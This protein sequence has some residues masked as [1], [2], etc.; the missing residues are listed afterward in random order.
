MRVGWSESP[1]QFQMGLAAKMGS[2][3]GPSTDVHSRGCDQQGSVGVPRAQT[4]PGGRMGRVDLDE[5]RLMSRMSL[6]SL[7]TS[8]PSFSYLLTKSTSSQHSESGGTASQIR[9]A[10]TT[11]LT[12]SSHLTS[13]CTHH[14]FQA[15]VIIRPGSPAQGQ[16]GVIA[17]KSWALTVGSRVPTADSN[18]KS[19]GNSDDPGEKP[20]H[21]L[22][23]AVK[24]AAVPSTKRGPQH[25]GTPKQSQSPG[26]LH[27]GMCPSKP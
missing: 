4:S 11:E 3:G 10:I 24:E 6:D 2:P 5:T 8:M 18:P 16:H 17:P 21:L 14:A 19:V 26:V 20:T 12:G 15:T 22:K 23:P 27:L 1:F 13:V 7:Q 25:L 9:D